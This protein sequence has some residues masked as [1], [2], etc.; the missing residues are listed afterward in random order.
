MS[1][2][3]PPR[4]RRFDYVGTYGYHVV[5]GTWDQMPHFADPTVFC[6]VRST[7]LLQSVRFEFAV[8]AYCFMPDH[9]H[10]LLQ[11]TNGRSSLNPFMKHWKQLTGYWS[12]ESRLVVEIR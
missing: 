3:H 2:S 7:L 11:G 5:C 6:A 8:N 10:L 4:L 12:L 9:V 1:A